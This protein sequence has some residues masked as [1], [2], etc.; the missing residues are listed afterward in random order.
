M[1]I[2]SMKQHCNTVGELRDALLDY[3]ADTPLS[4]EMSPMCTIYLATPEEGEHSEGPTLDICG[5]DPWGEYD[6]D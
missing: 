2:V 1:A 4:C 3:D 6:D 5:D